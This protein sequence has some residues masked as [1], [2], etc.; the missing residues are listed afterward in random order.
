MRG[1][2]RG[3][4]LASLP[5]PLSPSDV[6][7][8][9]SQRAGFETPTGSCS[10]ILAFFMIKGR[11]PSRPYAPGKL[12]NGGAGEVQKKYSCKGKRYEKKLIPA[13]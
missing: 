7:Y 5:N 8:A 12:I 2:E 1:R 9:A 11:T 4:P 3:S 13:N 10:R 6:R